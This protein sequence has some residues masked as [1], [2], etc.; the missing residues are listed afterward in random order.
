MKVEELFKTIK[1]MVEKV[2]KGPALFMLGCDDEKECSAIKG[3]EKA[4]ITMLVTQMIRN[5]SIERVIMVA[6]EA[7]IDF[8]E[9]EMKRAGKTNNSNVS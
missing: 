4:I 2:D 5:E 1:P 6:A 8:A 7:F 3:N 9:H